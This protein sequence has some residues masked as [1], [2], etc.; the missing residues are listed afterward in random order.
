MLIYLTFYSIMPLNARPNQH[1]H[2]MLNI[3][4]EINIDIDIFKNKKYLVW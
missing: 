4:Y 3:S 2:F 1:L